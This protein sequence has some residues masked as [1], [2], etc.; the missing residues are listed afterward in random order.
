[1]TA[2]TL[3]NRIFDTCR[4]IDNSIRLTEKQ[5]DDLRMRLAQA[6]Y[7]YEHA[8]NPYQ[9][10]AIRRKGLK[11]CARVSERAEDGYKRYNG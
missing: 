5:K 10:R 6:L 2:I 11:L 7:D 4:D 8:R 3:E 9:G 1:M